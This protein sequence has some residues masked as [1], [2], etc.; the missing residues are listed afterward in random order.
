M[1]KRTVVVL[2]IFTLFCLV[3]VAPPVA[4]AGPV[5][6]PCFGRDL[7]PSRPLYLPMDCPDPIQRTIVKTWEC[8]IEGPC[9][10]VMPAAA[11]CRG[12]GLLGGRDNYGLLM[13]AA[14]IFGAPFDWIF[15][16]RGGVYGCRSGRGG[17]LCGSPLG[18][19]VPGALLSVAR[20]PHGAFFGGLW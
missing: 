14:N 7:C 3:A 20:I 4:F 8:N 15:A 16:G 19:F 13:S 10:P 5:C 2:G 11:C 18:G 1:V 12:G 9:P 17:G 6:G